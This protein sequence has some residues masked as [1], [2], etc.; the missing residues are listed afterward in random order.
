[1]TD[2][3]YLFKYIL[4]GDANVG[5]SCLMMQLIEQ[6]FKQH[7]D[8]TIGVEFG[9]KKMKI[10]GKMIKIQIWDTAGQENFRSITRA[11]FRGAIG[12]LI[13]FDLCN[14][15]SFENLGKW[16][17]ETKKNASENIQFIL[18]GNK[19]DLKERVISE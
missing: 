18:V 2:Y 12:G 3:N 10:K 19:S 6:K 5:K 15:S 14:R 1:M 8:P 7:L 4:I 9:S 13:V 11:Y 17:E 16:I